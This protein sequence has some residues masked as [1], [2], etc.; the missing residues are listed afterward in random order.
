MFAA[1]ERHMLDE[2]R[3]T[4]FVII[5]IN[6]TCGYVEVKKRAIFRHIVFEDIK[7][8]AIC[9]LAVYYARIELKRHIRV[10]IC[11]VKAQRAKQGGDKKYKLFHNCPWI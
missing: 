7:F 10:D 4:L 5:F 1:V 2:M 3:K 11:G 8:H 9:Q 6:T